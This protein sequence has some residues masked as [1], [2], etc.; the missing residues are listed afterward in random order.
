MGL[1][2]KIENQL[3]RTVTVGTPITVHEVKLEIK[4]S[5]LPEAGE[6]VFALEDIPEGTFL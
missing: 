4:T 2:V 5:T 1:S 3:R 6:G